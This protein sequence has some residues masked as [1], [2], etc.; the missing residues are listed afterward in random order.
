MQ[1]LIDWLDERTGLVATWRQLGAVE[2]RSAGM[3]HS[4]GAVFVYLF[5]QQA[6]LGVLLATYYSPSASDAWAST[7]YLNDQ[8]TGGWL[9]RGLHHHGTSAMVILMGVYFLRALA[10]RAYRRPRELRWLSALLMGALIFAFAITGFPLPWDQDGYW[11]AKIRMGIIGTAP[12]GEQI[13][14][15]LTAGDEF[16]NLTLLR[17][18]M[19]HIFVLP[20]V[21]VGALVVHMSGVLRERPTATNEDDRRPRLSYYPHQLFYD[22]LA[23]TLVAAA[24]LGFTVW[25]HG[26]P[27]YA[28]AQPASSYIARPEWYF[29]SLFQLLKVF[30]G[31][32]QIVATTLLPGALATLLVALPWLDPG[33]AST[34]RRARLVVPLAALLMAGIGTLTAIAVAEDAADEVYQ[35]NRV[36]AR[37]D[38]AR[39]RD[40]ALIGVLPHGGDA[41]YQNDPQVAARTLFADECATCHAIDGIGGEEA[42]NLTNYGDRQWLREVIRNPNDPL[43]YGNTKLDEMEAYPEDELPE[44]QLVAVVEYLVSLAGD[45]APPFDANLAAKGKALFDDELDCNNCHETEPG[46][47][48]DGPNL[49]GLGSQAWIARVIADSSA[50][51]LFGSEAD[52]PKFVGKLSEDDLT[53]IAEFVFSLRDADTPDPSQPEGDDEG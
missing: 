14:S 24:L 42:P 34:P 4:I 39:A 43:K 10:V 45:D 22:V 29:L 23:V 17:F 19:L 13:V 15:L 41:V 26:A 25:S 48:G 51:D 1:P 40:L 6:A 33:S 18:Y 46:E 20:V 5:F 3:Q 11:G 36:A 9:L 38:A 28:P 7:A 44:D 30:D 49:S 53:M 31:P 2:V 37:S 8:V 50:E 35:K 47:S 32:L 12:G 27:L 16:G 52:M 21:F